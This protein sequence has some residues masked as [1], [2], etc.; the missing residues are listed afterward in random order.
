MDS[1]KSKFD[2]L[3]RTVDKLIQKQE[4]L[5]KSHT[6]DLADLLKESTEKYN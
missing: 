6:K 2:E 1:L 5:K 3:S 4:E